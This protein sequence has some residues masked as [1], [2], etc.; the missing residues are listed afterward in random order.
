MRTACV[1]AQFAE[2]FAA[3]ELIL[4]TAEYLHKNNIRV[5][6]I[7][8]DLELGARVRDLGV[9]TMHCAKFFNSFY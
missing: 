1:S 2:S 9:K 5:I 3:D 6:V 7:T 8:S 4:E